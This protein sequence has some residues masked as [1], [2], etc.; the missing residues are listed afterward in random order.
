[1][2]YGLRVRNAAGEIQIDSQYRNMEY[3]EGATGV[4]LPGSASIAIASSPLPP[5]IL[6]RPNTDYACSNAFL[7]LSS[8]N[9]TNFGMG[10]QY[11]ATT[12]FDWRC[13][14]QTITNS[15]G[16]GLRIKDPSGNLVYHSASSYFKIKSI[17]SVSVSAPS[18]SSI[19]NNSPPYTDIT[20]PNDSNPYYILQPNGFWITDAQ[21]FWQGFA[22]WKFFNCRIGIKKL[23]ATSV[24]V[25]WYPIIL[26]T[27]PGEPSGV[28]AG[29]NPTYKL[30]VCEI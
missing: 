11:N 26:Y 13:Y 22:V 30:V 17:N 4:S 3:T 16:Y 23:S 7:T 21:E 25:T 19:Y 5:L 28:N 24:R 29:W 6:I 27:I 14:R 9:Y 8:G 20:H 15:P 1:M 18:F 12:T 10:C 2:G